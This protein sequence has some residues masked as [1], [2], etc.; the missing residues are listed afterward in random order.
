MSKA[1][2]APKAETEAAP[3]TGK[4]KLLII[5]IGLLAVLLLGGGGAAAWYFLHASPAQASGAKKA[6]VDEDAGKPPVFVAL[7]P[8][9]VNLAPTDDGDSK[10]LQIAITVQI[11][12]D[13]AGDNLKANMPLVRSRVLLLLSSQKASDL[14]TEA[15]KAALMKA[16]IAELTKPF[17]P[18]APPQ[19]IKGVFFTSF[20]IQ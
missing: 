1:P 7:D 14:L 4:S 12:D 9:T 10:Y 6:P 8:F 19:K 17:S 13:K 20:V 16:I 5:V 3:V 15:G 11:P 2:P 18:D